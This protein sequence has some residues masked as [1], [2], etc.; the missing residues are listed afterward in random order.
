M[1]TK[2]NQEKSLD[3]ESLEDL[4][5]H[6]VL[7]ESLSEGFGVVNENNVLTYVNNQLAEMLGLSLTT[8]ST[9]LF[10]FC[11]TL[12]FFVVLLMYSLFVIV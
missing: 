6:R 12:M 1:D 10:S 11:G 7:I 8:L 5:K 3:I 9:L 2:P 4:L